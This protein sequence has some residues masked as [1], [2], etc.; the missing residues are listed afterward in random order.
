MNEQAGHSSIKPSAPAPPAGGAGRFGP[1]TFCAA[2]LGALLVAAGPS[3]VNEP[4]RDVPPVGFS[5][6][7]GEDTC[8]ACHFE[9]DLNPIPGSLILEDVPERYV[10][11]ETY[12]IEL[13][14]TRPEVKIAGF[15]MTV[16][17]E[18]RGAQAGSLAPG[19]GEAEHMNVSTSFDVQYAHHVRAGTDVVRADTARWSLVW[20]AP[21]GALGRVLF[22]AAANAANDDDSQFGDYIYSTSVAAL[23]ADSGH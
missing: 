14:L 21:A 23:P 7:F 12:P 22:H 3:P 6:G 8:V 4:S 19:P 13:V 16:R 20:T 15:E 5:G 9:A 17:F 11:G 18:G 10:P 2:L 1:R